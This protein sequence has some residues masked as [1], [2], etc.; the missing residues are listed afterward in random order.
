[1]R[2]GAHPAH[3]I[4][5]VPGSRAGRN[6]KHVWPGPGVS[7]S[8]LK[9]P[10]YRPSVEG[11]ANH[12]GPPVQFGCAP[13]GRPSPKAECFGPAA[14]R[15]RSLSRTGS[16]SCP[17]HPRCTLLPRRPAREPR[18]AGIRLLRSRQSCPA[19]LF[20]IACT[21]TGSDLHTPCMY[22]DNYICSLYSFIDPLAGAAHG[23]FRTVPECCA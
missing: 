5:R 22:I 11:S 21:Y 18:A 16:P 20:G 8:R 9:Y 3:P 23:S 12:T 4:L 14:L 19:M 6:V 13:V 10:G 2:T 7:Y 15:G 17:P 1:M